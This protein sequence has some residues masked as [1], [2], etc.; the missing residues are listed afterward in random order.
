[1]YISVQ[2]VSKMDL[3]PA[4]DN[5]DYGFGGRFKSISFDIPIEN[6]GFGLQKMRRM[7]LEKTVTENSLR[8]N[9]LEKAWGGIHH[10]FF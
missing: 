3:N 10:T 1:M 4:L 2:N 5:I 8:I 6:H 9:Q 7:Y